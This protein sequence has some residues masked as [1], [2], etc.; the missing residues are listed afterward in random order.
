VTWT[1]DPR[2]DVPPSRQLVE[3]VLDAIAVGELAPG[4]QLPSVRTLAAEALVNHNT[5]SKAYAELERH[6]AVEGQN[7]RG[8]FVTAAGPARARELRQVATRS[9]FERVAQEA[10]RAGHEPDALIDILQ[11]IRRERRTA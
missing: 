3:I 6:G 11:R 2:S 5:V 1:V 9:A 10:L 7:G 8:V 4:A